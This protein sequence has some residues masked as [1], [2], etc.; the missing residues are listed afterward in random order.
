M[1]A[2]FASASSQRLV[3]SASPLV[4]TGYPFSC[5]GWALTTTI[6]TGQAAMVAFSDGATANNYFEVRR[7]AANMQITAAGGGSENSAA[8]VAG[9]VA[10]RWTYFIA[11]FISTTN[12]HI[13]AILPSGEALHAT[14]AVSRVPT[15]LDALSVGARESSSPAQFWDGLIAE[16][17]FTQTDIQD[18]G[19][20]L[21]DGLLRQLAY[22]GPFSVQHIAKDII[23]Y[24]SFRKYPS[25]D[26]DEIGEVFHGAAGRQTWT[27][28][29]GVTTGHHPPLPYWHEKPG[30]NRRVLTI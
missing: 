7:N 26:G 21:Q 2:Q 9:F 10:D 1:A 29:N 11:R 19:A 28:T 18:D 6:G 14:T 12:R 5:G 13:A 8:I 16:F 22:G 25:S 15:S 23:E 27:N 17:W 4:S 20:Q 30:Q 24:R 3:N